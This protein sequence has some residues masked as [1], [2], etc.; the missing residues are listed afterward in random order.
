MMNSTSRRLNAIASA[1]TRAPAPPRWARKISHC[2][3]GSFAT[4][5]LMTPTA[6]SLICV[7]SCDFQ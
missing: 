4:K 2:G 1:A 7:K 6:P 5:S 3:D